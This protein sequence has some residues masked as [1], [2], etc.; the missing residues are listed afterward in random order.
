MNLP[1]PAK[2]NLHLQILDRRSDGFHEIQTILQ[3]I[4]LADEV[5]VRLQGVGLEVIGEGEP[6]PSGLENLAGRAA[7][8]F[9]EECGI[10]T[11]VRIQ[12]K[13]RIPVAAGLGGGSSNAA[14]V[15]LLLNEL[16][17]AGWGE[18]RLR[19]LGTRIG[20]DVPFFLFPGPAIGR[21]KGER[22]EAVELPRPLFFLLAI[23][24]FRIE[25]VWAYAAYDR[26]LKR[27]EEAVKIEKFYPTLAD[28]LPVLRNDLQEP[29]FR[30]FPQ[31]AGLKQE[32]LARG[33][34]GAL[35]SGSG[36]VSFGLFAGRGEA[37]HAERRL[38]LPAGWRTVVVQGL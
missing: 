1:S 7:Q 29:V 23:P 2:V 16:L 24:P 10:R 12:L 34:A 18:E 5:D 36:P 28:L 17:Q 37:E 6:V 22:L 38:K 21:G 31:I 19:E 25:T 35:M 11:G 20:A 33:A 14:S 26:A 27:K 15:L 13:K 4:D 30:R 8:A 32:L 9:L 3:R